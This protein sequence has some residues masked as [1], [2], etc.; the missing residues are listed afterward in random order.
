[1]P[2]GVLDTS[3]PLSVRISQFSSGSNSTLNA[4]PTSSISLIDPP[5]DDGQTWE[6]KQVIYFYINININFP[7]V[8]I[9]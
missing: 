5:A 3:R 2:G 7:L 6:K 4:T 9:R 1:M 8:K